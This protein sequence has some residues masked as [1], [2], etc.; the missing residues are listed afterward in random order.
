MKPRLRRR[1]LA[2]TQF[3][4]SRSLRSLARLEAAP[5]SLPTQA[6]HLI[7]A[8]FVRRGGGRASAALAAWKA[9]LQVACAWRGVGGP[10]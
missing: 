8:A 6:P 4:H 10:P 7:S 5:P 1:A 9:A 3:P 2:E